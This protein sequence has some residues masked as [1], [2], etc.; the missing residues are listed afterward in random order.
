MPELDNEKNQENNRLDNQAKLEFEK[1]LDLRKFEIDNFLE[2][3]LVFWCS[4][5]GNFIW[6]FFS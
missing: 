1:A 5:I 6:I 4:F 3:R 2:K